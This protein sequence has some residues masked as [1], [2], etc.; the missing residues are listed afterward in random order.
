MGEI[1]NHKQATVTLPQAEKL[2]D[3]S[4]AM[5]LRLDIVQQWLLA[6]RLIWRDAGGC[7]SEFKEGRKARDTDGFL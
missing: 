7:L 4:P 1:S 2:A 5:V 3:A 6:N